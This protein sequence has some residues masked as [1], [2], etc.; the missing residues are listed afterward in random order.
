MPSTSNKRA[1][2]PKVVICT[3]C[4]KSCEVGQKAMSIFCPHCRKRLILED[5]KITSYH[6]VREF[7]TCGD[8]VVEKKGHICA[9]I[10]AGNVTV[11]GKIQGSVCARG[12]VKVCKTG[13]LQADVIAPRLRV[14]DGA[15]LVG[16]VRIGTPVDDLQN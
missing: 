1:A 5:F 16:F 13:S 6:G 11:K 12:A 8:I 3:H 15:K 9:K 10:K 2:P 7:A 4:T 14:E